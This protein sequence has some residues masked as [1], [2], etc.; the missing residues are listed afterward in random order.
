MV[1]L[2]VI[3]PVYNVEHYL[4]RCLKSI[5][6]QNFSDYEV[7]LIDDQ[8]TD[9]SFKIMQNYSREYGFKIIRNFEN[10]G[11]SAT[12]NVGI[13]KAVG[14]YIYFL[15]SDDWLDSDM[16]ST[17]I[18]IM[19]S[20]NLDLIF[21][22][23]YLAKSKEKYIS[24]N[25][26]FNRP[27]GIVSSVELLEHIFKQRLGD[28]S[29]SRVVRRSVLIDNNIRYPSDTRVFEDLAVT[30]QVIENS[31]RIRL[32]E[33][34]F[35]YY[36]RKNPKSL[37]NSFTYDGY[38]ESLEN[39]KGLEQNIIIKHPDMV[40]CMLNYK[41]SIL[42]SLYIDSRKQDQK[43]IRRNLLKSFS[44][45]SKHLSFK[46]KVKIFMLNL[47]ILNNKSINI[48]HGVKDRFKM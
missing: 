8:S 44:W 16:F 29:W 14:K 1:K 43:K 18:S 46:N 21:F 41:C 38:L 3:V 25:L 7:I 5:L 47:N 26:Y 9:D 17:I 42:L 2:S 28:Y 40:S 30:Y 12:R 32:I 15:D 11:L 10:V 35:Y 13:S 36:F 4:D 45:Y 31:N 23:F 20:D 27:N 39:F 19:E 22:D 48:L 24:Q 33:N 37:T 34:K 6:A